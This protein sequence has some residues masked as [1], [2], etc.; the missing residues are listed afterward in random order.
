MKNEKK[1]RKE[2][3]SSFSVTS[4]RLKQFCFEFLDLFFHFFNSNKVNN[5]LCVA[6][7]SCLY[8]FGHCIVRYKCDTK[9]VYD[10]VCFFSLWLFFLH[11][12][13]YLSTVRILFSGYA[14]DSIPHFS[15]I[16]GVR[17]NWDR[18]LWCVC[19]EL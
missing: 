17:L 16:K 18:Q 14:F 12:T 19:C 4:I 3:N 8:I 9:N 5:L 13:S 1:E 6:M 15:N 11:R 7:V 2:Q 10:L